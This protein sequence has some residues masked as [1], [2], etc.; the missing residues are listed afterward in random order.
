MARTVA[1]GIVRGDAHT[2]CTSVVRRRRR[3]DRNDA[4]THVYRT[5]LICKNIQGK[6]I[7]N[8]VRGVFFSLIALILMLGFGGFLISSDVRVQRQIDID[9]PI[10]RVYD[11]VKDM[12]RFNVW[13]PWRDLDPDATYESGGTDG[14]VGSWFAWQSN[15]PGVGSGKQTITSLDPNRAVVMRLEFEGQDPA[16]SF[17]TLTPTSTGTNVVWGFDT[18]LGVNPYMRY[19]SFLM[20]HFLGKTYED[21]LESLKRYVESPS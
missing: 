17:F 6:N 21:G 10:D 15:K 7:V 5:A 4:S 8:I 3:N 14:A 13:S 1:L 12:Q 16:S 9:A 11:V 19:V 18:N 20:D 2:R